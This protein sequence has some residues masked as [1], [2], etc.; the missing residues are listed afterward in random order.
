MAGETRQRMFYLD[1]EKYKTNTWLCFFQ[2]PLT[3]KNA[4][5]LALLSEVLK[6][7]TKKF[8]S[9]RKLEE[10]A[11]EMYGAFWDISIVKKGED[12]LLSFTL[13]V[14]KHIDH[15]QAANFLQ[16]LIRHS[17]LQAGSFSEEQLKRQKEVLKRRL[18]SLA[19]DKAAFSRQRAAELTA[20]NGI[21]IC[22]DGYI[23]DID[24]ITTEDLRN[25]YDE[26]LTHSRVYLFFCGDKDGRTAL[27][28]WKKSLDLE[29]GVFWKEEKNTSL[30]RPP[31]WIR[32]KT[33]ATQARLI[34][35]FTGDG[36]QQRAALRVWNEILGVGGNSL[37]F[38]KIREELGLCYEIRSFVPPLTEMLFIEV[39]LAAKDV[40]KAAKEMMKIWNTTMENGIQKRDIRQAVQSLQREYEKIAENAGRMLDFAAEEALTGRNRSLAE[41]LKEISKVREK[42]IL[43]VIEKLHLQ[44]CY[45]LTGE[46]S[47]ADETAK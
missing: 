6:T 19:D 43:Q 37:L 28:M 12:A 32:E 16:E 29:D 33:K 44:T 14:L 2:V 13:E 46:E 4:T 18:E 40:R 39:G 36:Q 17:L 7:G 23:E 34:L 41:L 22:A 1:G 3:R 8:P 45:V 26:L 27:Q 21:G 24:D 9:R 31:V 42:D 30:S 5:K 15:E 35:V 20:E 10:K 11:E 25:F 47:T 38:R